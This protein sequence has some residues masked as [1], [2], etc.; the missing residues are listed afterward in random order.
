MSG[1]R[2]AT[3][4]DGRGQAAIRV[5][6]GELDRPEAET[7]AFASLLA[8]DERARADRFH[9]ERD[10]RRF[11]VGRGL[12]RT[13]LGRMLDVSPREIAFSYGTRGK[14]ALAWPMGTG[15]EFNLSHSHGLALVATTWG[16]AIGVDLEY[17]RAELDVLGLASRYFTP[18]EL[19]QIERQPSAEAQRAAFFRG[20][21]R[22]EAFLK[23]RGDGLWV[24]L[25][26]FEVSIDPPLPARVV[27]TVWDP[28]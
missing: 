25:D 14:P 16:R 18:E 20:W 9:F 5:W 15:L 19:S 4:V 17:R 12:L 21:A 10:R 1:C 2:G 27:R 13:L 22:K 26:Q 8:A 11:A 7:A 24:G 6:R 3:I 28:D 23:A